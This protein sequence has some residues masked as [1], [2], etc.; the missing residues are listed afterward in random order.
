[1]PCAPRLACSADLL[2]CGLAC[3]TSPS[4]TRSMASCTPSSPAR[5]RAADHT[6]RAALA[7]LI[8]NAMR[9]TSSSGACAP[10]LAGCARCRRAS[11]EQLLEQRVRR[12]HVQR[13]R[14]LQLLDLHAD[15]AREPRSASISGPASSVMPRARSLGPPLPPTLSSSIAT[16]PKPSETPPT[17]RLQ[18]GARLHTCSDLL[19]HQLR[20]PKQ[21]GDAPAQDQR[22]SDQPPKPILRIFNDTSKP[23]ALPPRGLRRKHRI[24][25][26]PAGNERA[27]PSR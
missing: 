11:R 1:M 16:E 3:A 10:A 2:E 13:Q 5:T 9:C 14:D 6:Q 17:S 27:A 15:S 8:S 22:R 21:R 18:P 23:E 12:R 4:A 25:P 20:Q 26:A 24:M 7:S 19:A